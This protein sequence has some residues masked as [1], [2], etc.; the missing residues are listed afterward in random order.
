MRSLKWCD[1][2]VELLHSCICNFEKSFNVVLR[3]RGAIWFDNYRVSKLTENQKRTE[4]AP[5]TIQLV[6]LCHR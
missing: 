5:E 2:V 3:W 4:P 6:Q 1:K